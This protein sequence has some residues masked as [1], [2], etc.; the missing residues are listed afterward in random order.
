[1]SAEPAI[2]FDLDEEED[3]LFLQ[4]AEDRA[5]EVLDN[6]GY[7]SFFRSDFNQPTERE[8]FDGT[9]QFR[10][11]LAI[12]AVEGKPPPGDDPFLSD[13]EI[14]FLADLSS[15]EGEFPLHKYPLEVIKADPI[16]SRVIN[17]RLMALSLHKVHH[18][19]SFD[20]PTENA[21]SELM[22]WLGISDSTALISL[23]G[24][25]EELISQLN[26]VQSFDESTYHGIVFFRNPSDTIAEKSFKNAK[27]VFRT[28]LPVLTT[29]ARQEVV[30]ILDKVLEN[31]HFPKKN[32]TKV[33]AFE[34]EGINLLFVRLIQ[35]RL[36]L[37]G[38]YDGRL[39]EEMGPMSLSAIQDLVTMTNFGEDQPVI[40][41]NEFIIRLNKEHWAINARYLLS[42]GFDKIEKAMSGTTKL[43]IADG[44]EELGSR[45]KEED[46]D[47]FYD[48]LKGIVE[49]D[50]APPGSLEKKK[51]KKSK[52][53]G[54]FWR[55]I[56]RFF[57][58]V[59]N[60]ILRGVKAI[61]KALANFFNWIKNGVR[62]LVAEI[63]KALS[64]LK[65][66]VKFAFG[67]RKIV[68]D[69]ITSDYDF[70]F[71]VVTT[72]S[73]PVNTEMIGAHRAKT[74]STLS[75]LMK[76]IDFLEKVLPT[77]IGLLTPPIGWVKVGVKLVALIGKAAA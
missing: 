48:E 76:T 37:H 66:S 24:D 56:G 12:S 19:R 53:G 5:E 34:G 30:P 39:D 74:E 32:R 35:L 4:H 20:A 64:R 21:I 45:V 71:D 15:L 67:K 52:A 3:V 57:Q 25:V 36:W 22:A 50:L 41:I 49:R 59:R 18:G 26:A 46:K 44:V 58:K 69:S 68:T 40:H 7:I 17:F 23:T 73:G 60:M 11:E 61:K 1:M 8:V 63:K 42:L 10:Q 29:R 72:I 2:D 27:Q 47:E 55:R 77:A 70:D 9:R 54:R 51:K 75:S 33:E 14:D 62:L 28:T 65:T 16:L 13:G 31:N 6:L 43:Q 38:T